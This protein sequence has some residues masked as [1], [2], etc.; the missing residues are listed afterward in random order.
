[1]F[2]S[3]KSWSSSQTI[4]TEGCDDTSAS[5]GIFVLRERRRRSGLELRSPEV[6]GEYDQVPQL[7]GER[8]RFFGF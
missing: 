8:G 1:M 3:S 5:R 7:T 2:E 4:S 6:V